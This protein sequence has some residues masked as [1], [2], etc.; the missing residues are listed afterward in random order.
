[1]RQTLL[2]RQ[3]LKEEKE[4]WESEIDEFL[5]EFRQISVYPE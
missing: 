2:K 3:S 1:M 4:R 5:R